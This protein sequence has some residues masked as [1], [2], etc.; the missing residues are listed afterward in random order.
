MGNWYGVH[1]ASWEHKI[2]RWEPGGRG[3]STCYGGKVIVPKQNTECKG[4]GLMNKQRVFRLHGCRRTFVS[5]A[6][7]NCFWCLTQ[8]FSQ[9]VNGEIL[10]R[11]I[12]EFS[13][14]MKIW[15]FAFFAGMFMVKSTSE[16]LSWLL[17]APVQGFVRRS[18]LWSI[19]QKRMK[20]WFRRVIRSAAY[21]RMSFQWA[22][23]FN[24]LFDFF[25]SP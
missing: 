21:W 12:Q 4:N 20:A 1:L 16:L 6:V 13:A 24:I 10:G 5:G 14:V 15:M 11:D 23:T 7:R 9:G 19:A 2:T 18:Y 25:S 17:A 3:T 8:C 22:K